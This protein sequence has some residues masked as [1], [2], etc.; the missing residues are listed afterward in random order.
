M[1][2]IQAVCREIIQKD[3]KLKYFGDDRNKLKNIFFVILH[4]HD[5]KLNKQVQL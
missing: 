1:H 2:K 3:I 5:K 4:F